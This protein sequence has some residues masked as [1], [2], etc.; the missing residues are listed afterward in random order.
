MLTPPPSK[1]VLKAR[2]VHLHNSTEDLLFR[3][4]E[5]L[6]SGDATTAVSLY[7]QVL[8][9]TCPGHAIA[10]LNRAVAYITLDYPELAVMDSYRAMSL[11]R[12]MRDPTSEIANNL[13]EA[14]FAY[15]HAEQSHLCAQAQW[16]KLPEEVDEERA[17]NLAWLTFNI[18][19][20]EE[21]WAYSTL[22]DDLCY[23]MEFRAVYRMADA[24]QRCDHGA[25]ADALNVISGIGEEVSQKWRSDKSWLFQLGQ[26]IMKCVEYAFDSQVK[27]FGELSIK[28][29]M[30][31]KATLIGRDLYPWNDKELD[32]SGPDA[33]LLLN[34]GE[35]TS[36]CA[37][38][39]KY[40]DSDGMAAQLELRATEDIFPETEVLYE[41]WHF[42]VSTD[43]PNREFARI[44]SAPPLWN[45]HICSP[46]SLY[47]HSD[48]QD[49]FD[50]ILSNFLEKAIDKDQ[51][52]LDDGCIR[53]L[54][55]YFYKSRTTED[56]VRRPKSM[57]W[58]FTQNVVSPLYHIERYF[59][60]K[61][62]NHFQYL[63]RFDGWVINTLIAKILLNISLLPGHKIVNP[64]AGSPFIEKTESNIWVAYIAPIFNMIRVA[65][66]SQGETP[67]VSYRE[68]HGIVCATLPGDPKV[69]SIRA[70][71]PLLKAKMSFPEIVPPTG[72]EGLSLEARDLAKYLA[73]DLVE[74]DDA[75]TC[76][77]TLKEFGNLYLGRSSNDEGQSMDSSP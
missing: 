59:A 77:G 6:G 5:H 56:A 29:V 51:H 14:C 73:G 2:I 31:S 70:G 42:V 61:G 21:V 1:T 26:D 57:P 19:L 20:P 27:L 64:P 15:F 16:T 36:S 43:G 39:L 12:E 25:F 54:D 22:R 48:A 47:T 45:V 65:D 46:R 40:R 3:A 38:A 52:P 68:Y 66:E 32:F 49:L 75:K 60:G 24:L 67:N 10:F 72:G 8:Y 17:C 50:R 33:L 76:D 4:N 34:V 35:H 30:K 71:E 53:I 7:T 44:P 9:T 63:E 18:L 62:K 41:P 55:G 13:Y 23:M 74:S 69:P 58:N 37:P 11:C 28:E